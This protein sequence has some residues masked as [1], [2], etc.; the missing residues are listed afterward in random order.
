MFYLLLLLLIVQRLLEMRLG[1]RHLAVLKSKL[2]VP[3]DQREARG[4]LVLHAGWFVAL[5]VEHFLHGQLTQGLWW[6]GGLFLL[7]LCQGVRLWTMRAL[8][9]YWVPWPVS[10]RGQKLVKRGPYRYLKHPNYLIVIVE[11]LV[12]PVLGGCRVVLIVGSILNG[13]FLLK[14]IEREERALK[15]LEK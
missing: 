11:F 12:V 3:L 10:F 14:R 7:V 4:M 2:L 6:Y 9:V 15:L 1:K 5:I 8:G 13:L